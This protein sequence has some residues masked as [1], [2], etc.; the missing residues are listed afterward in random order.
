MKVSVN[1]PRYLNGQ[2]ASVAK[3]KI[4]VIDIEGKHYSVFKDD[5]RLKTG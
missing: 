1:D 3:G 4:P 2:L 5:P